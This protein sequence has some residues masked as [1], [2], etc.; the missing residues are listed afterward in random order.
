MATNHKIEENPHDGAETKVMT[1]SFVEKR[2]PT[3]HVEDGVK[4]VK[5]K[6]TFIFS[7]NNTDESYC[8]LLVG[9]GAIP[10]F[11]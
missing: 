4:H 11:K 7:V 10:H 3:T 9:C 2:R 6:N 1:R 5:Y 8:D